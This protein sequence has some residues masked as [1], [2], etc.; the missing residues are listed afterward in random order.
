MPCFLAIALSSFLVKPSQVVRSMLWFVVCSCIVN[1]CNVFCKKNQDSLLL[2]P[3]EV[4][5]KT[6]HR[7]VNPNACD[8]E[9]VVNPKIDGI[10]QFHNNQTGTLANNTSKAIVPT[11]P[12]INASIFI[13]ER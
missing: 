5:N 1:D 11:K 12:I 6:L 8:Q 13:S 3:C 10:N 9:I 2:N 4:L 7:T